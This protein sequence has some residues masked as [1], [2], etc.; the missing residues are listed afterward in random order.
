MPEIEGPPVANDGVG[1]TECQRPCGTG[2]MWGNN[3]SPSTAAHPLSATLCLDATATVRGAGHAADWTLKARPGTKI[4]PHRLTPP[5]DTTRTAANM[6]DGTATPTTPLSP[7]S[8]ASDVDT[9]APR[10]AADEAAITTV[11]FV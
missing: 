7:A 4:S 6:S 3:T 1:Q 2:G 10:N 8:V 5:A 11:N 9:T